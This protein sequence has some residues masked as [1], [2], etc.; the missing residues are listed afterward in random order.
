M[1]CGSY[2]NGGKNTKLK[3]LIKNP[4]KHVIKAPENIRVQKVNHRE[5]L[6]VEAG[7]NLIEFE[8]LN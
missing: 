6:F 1:H 4:Q 8:K 3:K 5:G 7:T 2:E